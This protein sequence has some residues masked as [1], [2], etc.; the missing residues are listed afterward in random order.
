[1]ILVDT[2]VWIDHLRLHDP[3]LERLLWEQ[4][5]LSHPFIVGEIAMGSLKQRD[6]VVA[7][8]QDLPQPL[9]ASDAEVLHFVHNN[10]LFGTGIGYVDAHLLTAVQLTP[11]TRLW[12]RDKLLHK[13]AHR[14]SIV[15]DPKPN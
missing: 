8:L 11:G 2:S 5:V 14:L 10:R 1:M 15:F 12:T 4:K 7:D 9:V 3:E 6:T 13:A